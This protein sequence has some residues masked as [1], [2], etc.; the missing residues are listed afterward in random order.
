MPKLKIFKAFN[1]AKMI[2]VTL[3]IICTSVIGGVQF[4]TDTFVTKVAAQQMIKDTQTQITVLKNM[5]KNNTLMI[6]E[7]RLMKYELKLERSIKLTPTEKREY[8][9]LKSKILIIDTE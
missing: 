1:D 8:E 3:A 2:I 5:S 6:L 4:I 9:Y 7:L